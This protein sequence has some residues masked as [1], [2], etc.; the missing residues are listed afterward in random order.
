MGV[1]IIQ[2]AFMTCFIFEKIH[3]KLQGNIFSII[4]RLLCL[5]ANIHS[6]F[7]YSSISFRLANKENAEHNIHYQFRVG[8]KVHHTA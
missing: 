4:Q 8:V 1:E 6:I 7:L 5:P 2:T 3:Y